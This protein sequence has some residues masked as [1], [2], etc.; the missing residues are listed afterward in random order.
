MLEPAIQGVT[1]LLNIRKI[2]DEYGLDGTFSFA[3]EYLDF[4]QFLVFM[5]DTLNSTF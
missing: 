2:E 4:E 3:A 5:E 1:Y